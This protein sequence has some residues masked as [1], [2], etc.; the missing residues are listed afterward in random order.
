M[1]KWE[2]DMFV[3]TR[4]TE[5]GDV[6]LTL[7]DLKGF[8]G[9]NPKVSLFSH[10]R[11]R[12]GEEVAYHTHEDEFEIYYILTGSGIYNDNGTEVAVESGAIT[13]TP[14][15]CGHSLKNTGSEMLEFIALIVQD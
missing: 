6:K 8:P 15:G 10:A 11:L 13:H 4:C 7:T 3:K 2:K 5:Q 14:T 1:V 9:M 12:P